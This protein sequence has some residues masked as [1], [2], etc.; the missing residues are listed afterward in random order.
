MFDLDGNNRWSAGSFTSFPEI[1]YD[2]WI[3]NV[4]ETSTGA[5]YDKHMCKDYPRK[6]ITIP[7]SLSKF[8]IDGSKVISNTAA[9]TECSDGLKLQ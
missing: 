3:E 6:Y 7:E 4:K 1:S 5:N 9:D 2:Y 8:K